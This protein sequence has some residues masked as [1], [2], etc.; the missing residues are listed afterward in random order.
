M[1]GRRPATRVNRRPVLGS[2][3][4]ANHSALVG[5]CVGE[6]MAADTITLLLLPLSSLSSLLLL[7]K[8]CFQMKADHPQ[9]VLL[10]LLLLAM[11]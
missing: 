2:W 10:L 4:D 8:L 6:V 3:C 1:T 9:T 7:T 5:H 11:N